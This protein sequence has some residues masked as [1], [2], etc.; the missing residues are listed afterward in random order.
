MILLLARMFGYDTP[1][2]RSKDSLEKEE[3][4]ECKRVLEKLILDKLVLVNF[5]DTKDKFGRGLVEL[6]VKRVGYADEDPF[7]SSKC[8]KYDVPGTCSVLHKE[9]Q[10]DYLHVNDFMIRTVMCS[11]YRGKTKDSFADM[12]AKFEQRLLGAKTK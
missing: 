7:N 11:P 9:R 8:G 3:A 5:L 12:K 6:Y 4:L 10:N 2:I 1:E